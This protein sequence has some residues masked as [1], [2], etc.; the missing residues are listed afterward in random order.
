MPPTTPQTADEYLAHYA[1]VEGSYRR[2]RAA[3]AG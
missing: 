1:A 3:A 2:A